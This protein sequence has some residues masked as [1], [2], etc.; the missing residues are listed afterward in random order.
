MSR[1]Q[2]L[3]ELLD[4]RTRS[5]LWGELN[6]TTVALRVYAC[7][8]W[9]THNVILMLSYY[10]PLTVITVF[11]FAL[12]QSL[13]KPR[14]QRL[15][16]TNGNTFYELYKVENIQDSMQKLTSGRGLDQVE[17]QTCGFS[18]N[19]ATFFFLAATVFPSMRAHQ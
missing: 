12:E 6:S 17:W 10:R 2:Q 4:T 15:I 9:H 5:V 8:E 1:V 19:F 16:S 18:R 7:Q 13:V 11:E 14:R 3:L